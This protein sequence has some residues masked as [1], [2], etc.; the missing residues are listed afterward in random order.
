MRNQV[1]LSYLPRFINLIIVPLQIALLTR[2]LSIADYGV[3]NMLLSSGF[4]AT[5]VFS[6]GLQ[7]VL[8]IKIPGR[9]L[10]TQ[11][12]FFKAVLFAESLTYIGLTLVFIGLCLPWVL[13]LL[14]IESKQGA[15]I[16][17]MA[18][19]FVNLLYNEF[20]RL[21]N[22]QKKIEIRVLIVSC[23]KILELGLLYAAIIWA[24]VTNINQLALIYIA[25][26]LILLTITLVFF[27]GFKTFL[28]IRLRWKIMKYALFFG[29]PL[30]VSDIAWKLIQNVDL[31]ML[32]SFDR[33]AELGLYAFISRLINYIYLAASP[34]IWV[35]YPYLVEAHYKD[36]NSLGVKS[37]TLLIAQLNHSIIFLS[38]AAGG[39]L[40]NLDWII[41]LLANAEYNR[42]IY[43]Y[44]LFAAYPLLITTM[45]I[46]QQILL[47]DKK[48][49]SISIS[50]LVGLMLN[51]GGNFVL[52]PLYGITGAI[53]STLA[54]VLS[55]LFIQS[56]HFS[57]LRYFKAALIA[58]VALQIFVI[59][60][61]THIS[62][63]W[64]FK[65]ILFIMEIAIAV[66][67]LRLMDISSVR[68]IFSH[69]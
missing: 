54:S 15:A 68:K 29:A 52:I 5:M 16:V 22:Y 53:I 7:K 34:I 49:R 14:K 27:K 46:G 51:I 59:G 25:L 23:E 43:D 2:H 48:T 57:L 42:N 24:G 17:I 39:L 62:M 28:Q 31:Y 26:Y 10:R 11:L 9:S 8:S 20:G 18:A 6:L 56:R 38:I 55:I 67:S 32:S 64:F 19:F 50:Y 40:I 36:G 44:F 66:I 65:N 63:P 30:I 1:M 13:H 3:W 4:I 35:I 45:Y 58:F 12:G 41:K 47:L 60:V 37:Q 61:L 21:L 69:T 33:K